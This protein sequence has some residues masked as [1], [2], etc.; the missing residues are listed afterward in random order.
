M[1]LIPPTRRTPSH[2][3]LHQSCTPPSYIRSSKF[4]S[5]IR[6]ASKDN[7]SARSCVAHLHVSW[8]LRLGTN[9]HLTP[10]RGILRAMR[11]WNEADCFDET[12]RRN[13][14]T[15]LMRGSRQS[16]GSGP[17]PWLSQALILLTVYSLQLHKLAPTDVLDCTKIYQL[18]QS[19]ISETIWNLPPNPAVPLSSAAPLVSWLLT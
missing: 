14:I 1:S 13:E 4:H 7:T 5:L 8:G 3:L 16:H 9:I 12:G 11:S 19:H 15:Y 10:P 6:A 2:A 18:F 17:D